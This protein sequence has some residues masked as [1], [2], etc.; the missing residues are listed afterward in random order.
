MPK[1]SLTDD[2]FV[3]FLQEL[4]DSNLV[5]VVGSYARGEAHKFSDLDLYVLKERKGMAKIIAIFDKHQVQ[6]ESIFI[7]CVG[8]PRN[9]E[10]M[11]LPVECSYLFTYLKNRTTPIQIFG[12]TFLAYES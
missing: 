5:R 7:G 1:L 8:S 12:V 10:Y 9:S 6:W 2:E 3:A 11:P 4:A